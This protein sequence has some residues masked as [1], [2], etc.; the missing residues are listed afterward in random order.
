MKNRIRNFRINY[1][2]DTLSK[3]TAAAEPIKQFEKWFEEYMEVSLVEFNAM[4]LSTV[5]KSGK[6]S[7]RVVLLKDFDQAG[8]VFFSNYQSRKGQQIAENPQG[9]IC[10]FWPELE[11][12]IRIEGCFEKLSESESDA[13]FATR[14]RKSQ[15]GAWASAQSRTLANRFT[16]MRSFVKFSY[17]FLN[18][19]VPRPEHWGGFRLKPDLFEFWQGRPSRLHDR[20]QYTLKDNAKW[21]I[22]RLSP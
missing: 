9:A 6:P 18:K 2:N 11:R 5:D 12:Q 17:K 19:P 21:Q 7:S 16:L 22:D 3:Q 14:P 8:F 15:L 13:Y 4:I 20:I 10:F 1:Q